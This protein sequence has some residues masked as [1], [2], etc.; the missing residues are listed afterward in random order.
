[1]RMMD[2]LNWK[3]IGGVGRRDLSVGRCWHVRWLWD[4]RHSKNIQSGETSGQ[5]NGV[6]KCTEKYPACW[7]SHLQA[8]K[9]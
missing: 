2:T 7:N 5:R 8:V 6:R 1:M 3:I 9:R 4:V